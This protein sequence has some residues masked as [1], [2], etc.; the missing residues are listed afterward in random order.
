MKPDP[1]GG[2]RFHSLGILG[3]SVGEGPFESPQ[4]RGIC[5][6]VNAHTLGPRGELPQSRDLL[7]HFWLRKTPSG[8]EMGLLATGR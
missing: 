6:T 3:R 4:Q 8:K 1:P 7:P 2:P 5:R